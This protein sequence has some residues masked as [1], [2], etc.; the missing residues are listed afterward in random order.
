MPAGIFGGTKESTPMNAPPISI[1]LN[2]TGNFE[3]DE[4]RKAVEKAGQT[5]Q[6]SFAEEMEKYNMERRR[7]AFG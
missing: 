4:I 7:L 6:R 5:V 2:F 3:P 1:S